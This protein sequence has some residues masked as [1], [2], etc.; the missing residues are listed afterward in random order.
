MIVVGLSA[1]LYGS[2]VFLR[3][4]RCVLTQPSRRAREHP[5]V[6]TIPGVALASTIERLI[7]VCYHPVRRAA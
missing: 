2:L 3:A 7:D 5:A 1:C 4:S 6:D